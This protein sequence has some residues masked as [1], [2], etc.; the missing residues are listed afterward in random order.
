MNSDFCYLDGL[1]LRCLFALILFLGIFTA[2][3]LFT[4]EIQ[5]NAL[6]QAA[7]YTGRS[8]FITKTFGFDE[9]GTFLIR[10][11]RLI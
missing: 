8:D 3:H 5:K 6:A 2:D 7:A 11:Q 10:I 1:K 4:E 9:K